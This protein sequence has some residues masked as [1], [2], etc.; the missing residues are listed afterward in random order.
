M[1]KRLVILCVLAIE[2]VVLALAGGGG[3]SGLETL[4]V[5]IVER[6]SIPD[7]QGSIKDNPWTAY[8]QEQMAGRGVDVR[9][10]AI[11]GSQVAHTIMMATNTAPDVSFTHGRLLFQKFAADGG[12]HDLG[13]LIDTYGPNIPTVLGEEILRYGRVDGV[14][15]AIPSRRE[16]DARYASFIRKDW[17]DALGLDP[18]TNREELTDVL[19]AFRDNDP[20]NVGA[21]KLIPWGWFT[22]DP[23]TFYESDFKLFDVMYSFFEHDEAANMTEIWPRRDGFREFMAWLNDL[24]RRGLIER[25][26]ATDNFTIKTRKVMNGEVGFVHA[27]YLYP[28]GQNSASIQANLQSNV[29]GAELI[30]VDVFQ[31]DAGEYRGLRYLPVQYYVFSPSRSRRPEVA[32]AYMN[33]LLED[34]IAWT[35]SFGVTGEHHTVQEGMPVIDDLRHFYDT[36]GY[37]SPSL[38]ILGDYPFGSDV[39]EFA[40]EQQRIYEYSGNDDIAR[41]MALGDSFTE[42]V[43]D[44]RMP[45][46]ARYGPGL[47]KIAEQYWVE[48]ITEEDFDAAYEEFMAKAV[49]RGVDNVEA[50]RREYYLRRSGE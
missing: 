39:Y 43:F 22:E 46:M 20:G 26:F 31:N 10:V 9:F 1:V 50:E 36:F 24:Y 15:Y 16:D 6:E 27:H 49:D 37:A 18:P 41:Q 8:V 12:L 32:V 7:G 25:E 29:P 17:L 4:R 42:P 13:P 30:P 48:M 44:E 47:I 33:W 40:R 28:Y 14:Q 45:S 38:R 35:L 21:E 2:V 34:D 5:M 19:Q 3:E 23:G 11:G